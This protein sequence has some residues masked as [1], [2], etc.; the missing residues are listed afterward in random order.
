MCILGAPTTARRLSANL[1]DHQLVS[2]ERRIQTRLG[3]CGMIAQV[4]CLCAVL[5]S[6]RSTEPSAPSQD[7]P[8][9]WLFLPASVSPRGSAILIIVDTLRADHLSMYGYPRLT[10]P[11]LDAWA[12][13][14]RVYERA[15]S[16]SSWTLPAFGTLFTGYVPMRHGAGYAE[17]SSK[18]GSSV[19]TIAEMLIDRGFRTGAVINN[20]YLRK[21]FGVDR[22]FEEYDYAPANNNRH[23]P[24]DVVVSR[25]LELVDRWGAE[26]FFLV[27]HFF[28]PHMRYGP[29]RSFRGRFSQNIE[30]ELRYPVSERRRFLEQ[31]EQLSVGDREF[32]KAAYDEEI[33]FVDQ[34]L[35]RLMNGLV[36]R[37]VLENTMLVFT[38]DHGEELFEHG[39]FEH[40]HEMWQEL[41]HVPL[42]VWGSGV[43]PGR[44][45]APVSLADV[46]PTVLEW[47]AVDIPADFDGLSL[48]PN[49]AG[50]R[51][52]PERT[53]IAEGR[54]YGDQYAA[55][56]IRWP[57]KVVV[58]SDRNPVRAIDLAADPDERTDLLVSSDD[59]PD[60]AVGGLISTLRGRVVDSQDE[61]ALLD[62]DTLESLRSLGYVR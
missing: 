29:P 55:A 11:N 47:A 31:P 7:E 34:E 52:F 1:S 62:D 56:A 12:A 20:P 59:R 61:P 5:L 23:R 14:G 37:G 54:L 10:S 16:T 45:S 9:G 60:G 25:S 51:Q 18:L 33:A 57:L 3:R 42:V 24:A 50:E 58:D 27:I 6:C 28:E 43:N 39:G 13:G 32:I 35:G 46:A 53:L 22:G 2:N 15:H 8:P 21:I 4:V 38:S 48:W 40:G 36:E 30:S 41:L 19:S 44:E 26:P 49:L 17:R